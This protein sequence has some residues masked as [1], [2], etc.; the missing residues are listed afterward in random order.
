MIE[1]GG[2]ASIEVTLRKLDLAPGA[3][4]CEPVN[5]RPGRWRGT[6]DA[7]RSPFW[8]RGERQWAHVRFTGDY[9]DVPLRRA[10]EDQA[11]EV[12]RFP[13]ARIPLADRPQLLPHLQ[14]PSPEPDHP[15]SNGPVR[16]CGWR[17]GATAR[18]LQQP[19]PPPLPATDHLLALLLVT[20][21]PAALRRLR[22]SRSPSLHDPHVYPLP[23]GHGCEISPCG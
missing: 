20:P 13:A 1:T 14:P 12:A 23:A 6:D 9:E 7:D 10:R 4:P 2:D 15:A 5:G 8:G 22:T 11:F 16:G 3:Q 18:G 17:P 19:P 21:P